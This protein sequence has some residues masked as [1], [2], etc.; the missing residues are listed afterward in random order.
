MEADSDIQQ[1]VV[2]CSQ[3]VTNQQYIYLETVHKG[4]KMRVKKGSCL[5]VTGL[6]AL[7][8]LIVINIKDDGRKEV[9]PAFIADIHGFNDSNTNIER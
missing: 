7:I 8:T 9:D 2:S 3:L 5:K 6:A 4:F 1:I